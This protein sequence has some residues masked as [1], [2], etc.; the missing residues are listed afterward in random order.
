MNAN[1]K[2]NLFDLM[3]AEQ[4]ARHHR[5]FL[6]YLENKKSRLGFPRRLLRLLIQSWLTPALN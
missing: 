4:N 2:A 6:E 3:L 5:G 1:I